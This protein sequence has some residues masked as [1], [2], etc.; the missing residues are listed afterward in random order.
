M[1][2]TSNKNK[3]VSKKVSNGRILKT[4]DN[5]FEGAKNYVKPGYENKG[6]YRKVVVVDSNKKDELA[7]VK[8]TTSNKGIPL[9]NYKSGKSRYRPYILIAD[10]DGKPIKIGYKFR[11]YPKK[12][13]LNTYYVNEIKN[14]C[15]NSVDS[16][17]NRKKLRKL[18]ER[19]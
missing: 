9:K 4:R 1:S 15:V 12:D 5:Y 14:K 2:L 19:K 13:S 18:K 8:L 17:R 3:N 16:K 6:H 10:D 7:V 11:Y